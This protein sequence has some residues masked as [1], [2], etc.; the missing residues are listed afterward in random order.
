MRPFCQPVYTDVTYNVPPLEADRTWNLEESISSTLDLLAGQ[1]SETP[2][3]EP[4][5][6]LLTL[7]YAFFHKAH[8]CVL[9]FQF[10]KQKMTSDSESVRLLVLVMSFIGSLFASSIPSGPFDEQVQTELARSDS[11][12][13]GF[14]AQAM[15]L[16]SIAVFW[17]NEID[18][19][20]KLLDRAIDLALGIG[21][22]LRDFA[23]QHG[24]GDKVLEESWRRTW[25]QIYLT[26]AHI[27][28]SRHM[29][30]F[31]AS[32]VTTDVDLPC[33][34]LEYES[35]VSISRFVTFLSLSNKRS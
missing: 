4:S 22:H 28:A 14:H 26:D 10:L 9:P 25:W 29:Q 24:M 7:Y 8:P 16:Y 23:I 5:E 2:D 21:M 27:A 17:R 34:E 3:V 6:Q 13:T 1:I 31:R 32:T 11:E 15:I 33:E 18:R 12:P 20:L 35:G 30:V 19:A